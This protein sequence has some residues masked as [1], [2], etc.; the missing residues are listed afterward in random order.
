LHAV[1][2]GGL[3]NESRA[4]TPMHDDDRRGFLA[5]LPARLAAALGGGELLAVF[6]TDLPGVTVRVEADRLRCGGRLLPSTVPSVTVRLDP[7]VDVRWL[8][9]V[10]LIAAPVG[11][12][13]DVHQHRWHLCVAG[14]EL[15]DP[16]GERIASHTPTAGRWDLDAV[17]VDRPRGPLPAVSSGASP[18]Y[19]LEVTGGEVA[20]VTVSRTNVMAELVPADDPMADILRASTD[21]RSWPSECVV[22][23]NGG[24]PLAVAGFHS[25]GR[26]LVADA[27]ASVPGARTHH[28]GS[29]L[30][31]VL[32]A[33]AL[34]RGLGIVR[35][36]SSVEP[37]ADTFPFR[38]HGY[39]DVDGIVERH[40]ARPS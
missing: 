15:P 26:V 37:L 36:G 10:W 7:P 9:E 2:V 24:S 13:G 19:D 39:S 27:F 16:H 40:L 8:S 1:D 17:L 32:E 29:A 31:D 4:V 34:D 38:R 21:E 22:V 28:A 5:E 11:V 18:A 3:S 14:A 30:L 35:L 12:S 20:S 25:A 33:V 23:M 6:S